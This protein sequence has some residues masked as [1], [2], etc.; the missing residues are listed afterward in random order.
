M[1]EISER[2]SW[3]VLTWAVCRIGGPAILAKRREKVFLGCSLSSQRRVSFSTRAGA[4]P[5]DEALFFPA[6]F[7]AVKYGWMHLS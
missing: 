3:K 1:K 2:H 6:Q 4:W 5:Y 7:T